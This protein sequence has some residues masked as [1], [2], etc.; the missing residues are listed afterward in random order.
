LK[1]PWKEPKYRQLTL[2]QFLKKTP[3]KPSVPEKIFEISPQNNTTEEATSEVKTE[4]FRSPRRT[5]RLSNT[6]VSKSETDLTKMANGTPEETI[7]KPTREFP[8]L[9]KRSN[10]CYSFSSEAKFT[11]TTT[12]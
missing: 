3:S 12:K 11:N 1:S 7:K 4:E 10:H 6:H 9:L 5:K 2:D 8:F